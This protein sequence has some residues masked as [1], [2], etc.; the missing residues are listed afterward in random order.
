MT[1]SRSCGGK[2]SHMDIEN[3]ILYTDKCRFLIVAE[4]LHIANAIH[5]TCSEF[6]QKDNVFLIPRIF[7]EQGDSA[8]AI[9]TTFFCEQ[10][11]FTY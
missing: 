6:L 7:G 1:C 9:A 8:E 5:M 11:V 4:G 2:I 10:P 3:R